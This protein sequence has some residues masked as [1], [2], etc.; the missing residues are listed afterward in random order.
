MGGRQLCIV[1]ACSFVLAG[2]GC[3]CNESPQESSVQEDD[4]PL[5][6]FRK[7]RR[8]IRKRKK[9]TPSNPPT[10]EDGIA[11]L[12]EAKLLLEEADFR[13]AEK[14][15]RIAAAAG[16]PG[17]DGLLYRVRNEIEA[18]DRIISAQKKIALLDFEGARADLEAVAPGLILSEISREMLETLAEKEGQKR[19]ATLEKA[20]QRIEAKEEEEVGEEEEPALEDEE[21]DEEDDEP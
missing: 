18:E 4:S 11:A 21:P 5:A 10:R 20:S 9:R 2:P 15:L 1:L 19:K 6:K 3:T 14:E 17:A 13:E 8:K 7:K 12:G 16:T